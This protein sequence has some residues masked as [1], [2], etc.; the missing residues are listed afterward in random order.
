[1]DYLR[2]LM[3]RLAEDTSEEAIAALTALR[4]APGDGYTSSLQSLVREQWQKHAERTYRPPG[5]EE[6]RTILDAGLPAT[7][8]D[9]QATILES[10]QT[11]QKLL[12]GSS[13]DWYRGFFMDDRTIRKGEED[14]RNEL[15]KLLT[16]VDGRFNYEPEGHVADDKRIDIVVRAPGR[17]I[18]PIEIKG[19]WNKEIWPAADTQLDRHYV[20]DWRAERGIY[21]V[22]WFGGCDLKRAPGS[23]SKLTTPEELRAALSASSTAVRDGRVDVVVLDLTRPQ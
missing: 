13:V 20:H 11:V 6:I 5:L 9:L 10:L 7:A 1:M 22:L 19:E 17:L 23:K 12:R 2:G 14:C 4:D 21:L 3:A 15:I 8:A 18:L 16:A